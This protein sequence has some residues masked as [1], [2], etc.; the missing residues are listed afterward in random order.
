MQE[1]ARL[2]LGYEPISKAAEAN[3][4]A[5]CSRVTENGPKDQHLFTEGVTKVFWDMLNE[6]RL[7]VK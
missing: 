1:S 3:L 5:Y 7:L 2:V 6:Y 4:L